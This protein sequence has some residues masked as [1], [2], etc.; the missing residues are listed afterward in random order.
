LRSIGG[1]T[2]LF[3]AAQKG[4]HA[5]V[6]ALLAA[7]PEVDNEDITLQDSRRS[8]L[9]LKQGR[10]D[11]CAEL[12]LNAGA[13]KDASERGGATALMSASQ[14][15]YAVCAD[16]LLKAGA[17]TNSSDCQGATALIH[18]SQRGHDKCAELLI[19]PSCSRQATI[20][21]SAFA[22][23][24]SVAPTLT[25]HRSKPGLWVSLRWSTPNRGEWTRRAGQQGVRVLPEAAGRAAAVPRLQGGQVRLGRVLRR[26]LADPQGRVQ[27]S[28]SRRSGWR[29]MTRRRA[30]WQQRR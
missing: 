16:L 8:S 13:N 15:G 24:F 22:R 7:G 28:R 9:R 30:R 14:N 11:K 19:R 26:A 17:D 5:C 1:Q 4:S 6:E 27:T 18:A 23:S 21:P 3:V 10:H 12:L 2:A 20:T 25:W 29:R